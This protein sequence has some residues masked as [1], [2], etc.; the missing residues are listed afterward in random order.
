MGSACSRSFRKVDRIAMP[1]ARLANQRRSADGDSTDILNDTATGLKSPATVLAGLRRESHQRRFRPSTS[2]DALDAEIA[3]VLYDSLKGMTMNTKRIPKAL[4]VAD[5]ATSL[6]RSQRTSRSS[7]GRWSAWRSPWVCA[8]LALTGCACG[9][10]LTTAGKFASAAETSTG[11]LQG[12]F[13]F[14]SNIC[15][16]RTQLDYFKHR[17]QGA[18]TVD[19]LKVTPTNPAIYSNEWSTRFSKGTWQR[20]CEDMQTNDA[21]LQNGLSALLAYATALNT[22]ANVDY[23]GKN[24]TTLITSTQTLATSAPIVSSQATAAIGALSGPVGQLG[25][26]LV[27][28]YA[29]GKVKELVRDADASVNAI[30][31]ILAHYLEAVEG[32][33]DQLETETRYLLHDLDLKV[34][35]GEPIQMIEFYEFADRLIRDTKATHAKQA[36]LAGA[37]SALQQAE[38][39]L[40]KANGS[41][42]SPSLSVVLEFVSTVLSDVAAVAAAT[43]QGAA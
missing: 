43:Q 35:A 31:G 17:L 34:T 27:K 26:V 20:L 6:A 38:Q 9:Q 28:T 42:S 8:M 4:V 10:Y 19:G 15:M 30:L 21:L 25:G 12:A 36:G 23:S 11:T 40:A 5:C 24:I 39:A 14:N 3:R 33:E 29:A 2:N 32:N 16:R 1:A 41:N 7:P 22:V 13:Q 18:N 37:L